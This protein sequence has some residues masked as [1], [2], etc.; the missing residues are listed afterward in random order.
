MLEVREI[1]AWSP[2]ARERLQSFGVFWGVGS[3]W[4]GRDEVVL[5]YLG[6]VY[7]AFAGDLV[8]LWFS[9]AQSHVSV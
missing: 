2:Q 6:G 4:S 5:G 8:S 3:G 9:G 7:G 1:F